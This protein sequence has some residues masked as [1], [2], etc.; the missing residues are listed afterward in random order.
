M[1]QTERSPEELRFT[2]GAGQ[3]EPEHPWAIVRDV[4]TA[5]PAADSSEYVAVLCEGLGEVADKWFVWNSDR[6]ED[7]RER[8]L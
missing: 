3:T 8:S 2:E 7:E 1:Q 5:A 4:I 6:T